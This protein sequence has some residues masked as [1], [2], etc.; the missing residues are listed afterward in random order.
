MISIRRTRGN[1]SG[2]AVVEFAIV[3]PLMLAILCG[4]LDF[5]WLY[6]NTCRVRFA[7]YEGSRCAAMYAGIYSPGELESAVAGTVELNLPDNVTDVSVSVAGNGDCITVTAGCGIPTLT[8]AAA[9]VYG[10]T[11]TASCSYTA[12]CGGGNTGQ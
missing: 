12:F 10:R 5:S 2:Q 3:L 8:F 6:L 9:A 11:Y 7:A 4:M 1:E